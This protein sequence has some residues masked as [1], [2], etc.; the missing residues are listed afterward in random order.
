[1]CGIRGRRR[2]GSGLTLESAGG[3]GASQGLRCPAKVLWLEVAVRPA[4]G[5][6]VVTVEGGDDLVG[7]ALGSHEG[8]RRVSG[9]VQLEDRH[10]GLLAQPLPVVRVALR[11]HWSAHLVNRKVAGGDVGEP[12][13]L[14]MPRSHLS[15]A[16]HVGRRQRKGPGAV[17]ALGIALNHSLGIHKDAPPGHGQRVLVEVNVRPPQTEHLGS[18]QPSHAEQPA[19]GEPLVLRGTDHGPPL[20]FRMDGR[21]ARGATAGLDFASRVGEYHPILD[22][23]FEARPHVDQHSSD[24]AD[25]EAL[26]R[27]AV[28]QGQDVVATDLLPW[29]GAEGVLCVLQGLGVAIDADLANPV[30]GQPEVGVGQVV[31][32][33]VARGDVGATSAVSADFV[34]PGARLG[35]RAETP[36]LLFALPRRAHVD[37]CSVARRS[38][39]EELQRDRLAG[40]RFSDPRH[41]SPRFAQGWPHPPRDQGTVGEVFDTIEARIRRRLEDHPHPVYHSLAQQIEKLRTQA[42]RNSEDSIEFL[43]KA[44]ELARTF[45]QAERLEAAGELDSAAGALL[46]PHIGALTQIVEEYKP[47]NTPVV[48]SDLVRDIDA[49]VREVSYTGWNETQAGDRTVRKEI[50]VILKKYALPLTG[51][52]FDNTYAYIRENY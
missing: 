25:T 20:S 8:H 47:A 16:C 43:K 12:H 37:D 18:A 32:C 40:P 10:A 5:L 42:I 23:Q 36:L 52:L 1:M 44:L 30:V 45:V 13:D 11:A 24:G 29:Q 6:L 14:G 7:D 4:H 39:L 31:E 50:R 2:R 49:I 26:G 46:D 28:D 3:A 15:Q 27:H 21:L 33:P 34:E 48:V 38:I 22:G 9:P 19:G 51:P 35:D 41:S 17:R